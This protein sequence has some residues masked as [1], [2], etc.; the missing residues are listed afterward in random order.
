MGTNYLVCKDSQT[1]R[2]R[3]NSFQIDIYYNSMKPNIHYSKFHGDDSS[4]KIMLHKRS[5]NDIIFITKESEEV[6][7][8][9]VKWM[10]MI[11]MKRM[12]SLYDIKS[13]FI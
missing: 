1:I 12:I 4:D 7:Q 10:I 8:W 5:N 3:I 9:L 13:M 11:L 2:L 6:N